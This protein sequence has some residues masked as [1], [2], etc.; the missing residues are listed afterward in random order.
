MAASWHEAAKRATI[1]THVEGDGQFV[2]D[3]ACKRGTGLLTP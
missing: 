3:H 1:Q 2:F